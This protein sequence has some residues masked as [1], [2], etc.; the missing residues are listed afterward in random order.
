CKYNNI[1]GESWEMEDNKRRRNLNYGYKLMLL[2][3]F[4]ILLIQIFSYWIFEP[5]TAF[6]TDLLEVSFLPI[7]LLLIFIVLFTTKK[8]ESNVEF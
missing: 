1:L 4:F 6:L 8:E 2:L 5:L 7:F 3:I